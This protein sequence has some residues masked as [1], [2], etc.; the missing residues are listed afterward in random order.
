MRTSVLAVETRNI[1]NTEVAGRAA[2]AA[3]LK[4]AGISKFYSGIPALRDV[5]VTFFPGEVHAILGENGAGKSTLMNIIAG[6]LQPELGTIEFAGQRVSP[7]TPE[8]AAALGISIS[9]QHPAILDDLSV[10]ENLQVAL[11]SSVFAG[12][13]VTETAEAILNSVG[14]ETKLR[15]RCDCL[16]V[17]QKQLL[18]I[19][20]ALAMKP[21]VLILDEPTASLDKD[22]TDLLFTRIR[23]LV[24]SG[25][26]VIYITHR[27]AELRQIAD[28]VTVLRDGR[29]R[30]VA[31]VEKV[32][33]EELLALIVGRA[34][35]TTFPPKANNASGVVNFSV[36][37]LNG[38]EF[39]DVSFTSC[40]GEIVGVAG[41]AGNGQSELMRALAGLQTSQG[42]IMLGERSVSLQDL[43]HAAAFM[44]S[45]RHAEGLASGLTIR[46]NAALSALDKFATLGFVSGRVELQQVTSAFNSLAVKAPS[47]EA[48]VRSL[49]G[50]NQQKVVLA[51]ALLS[52]PSLIVADEP[53]QGVDVGARAEIY[54]ILREIS[55]AGTPVIVNSSDAAELEG[56]CDRV[57]VLSR[58]RVVANLSG[59]EVEEASIVAAAVNSSTHSGSGE[60]SDAVKGGTSRSGW[61]HFV[62]TDNAP[63]IPLTIV[64]IIL[65][66]YVFGQNHN[67]LSSFNIYNILM[68]ATALGFIALGQTVA[69]MLSGIDLSVGPLAGFLVVVA[70]FFI[71]DGQPP[72]MIAAGFFLMVLGALVVGTVNGLLIRFANFTPIAATLAMYIGLQ[73]LSF[74]LR[75]GPGGYIN[76]AVVEVITWQLGPIPAAFLVLV[77]C[78]AGAEY[79]LRNRRAGWQLRATGSNQESARRIGLRID[80]VFVSG[81]VAS[82]LFAALGAI[83]LMA[84]I[85]VGD[86][87]QGVNYTLSSITAVVLGGTSLRGGRG[88]F[89]GT[90]LGAVLLTEV[91]NVVSFLGLSQTYQYVYQGALI[92]SAALI[93]TSV[94]GRGQS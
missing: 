74:V 13:P 24:K 22:A 53:T 5:H 64:T 76:A 21:K 90:V 15:E 81:Y 91:L 27:L 50:G 67:F 8:R 58:G 39:K 6:V 16:T 56:L 54:R 41:V 78:A 71:N 28:R 61:R 60:A 49:S 73:G 10:L 20:K 72:L 83:M 7:L 45:D 80:R 23:E 25:T 55:N 11:P 38:A 85:G 69:L 17:A 86:P 36:E 51:R 2:E 62:Q 79:A 65:A 84:Q 1:E 18:E 77:A 88:T 31:E 40:R 19:A 37:S 4:L 34:L 75:D 12:K 42:K 35:E 59:S 33:D 3:T 52:E 92:I 32:T 68:L 47:I 29:V 43:L 63:A 70:S 94:R 57:I 93:Y 82:S 44:P 89:I 48:P 66:L 9:Y 87:Q 14:L 26:A 46:E 30:G